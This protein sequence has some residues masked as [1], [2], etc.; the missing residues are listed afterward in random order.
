MTGGGAKTGP[1]V[2]GVG[3]T[4]PLRDNRPFRALWFA[5]SISFLGDSLGLVTLLLYVADTTGRALAVALL[6]LVGDFAPALLGPFTG[7]LSDRFDPKRVDGG[8]RPRAG[9]PGYSYRS[10][11]AFAAPAPPEGS[12]GGDPSDVSRGGGV[13]ARPPRTGG[14]NAR[15]VAHLDGYS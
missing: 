7:V 4:R 13:V 14:L 8:L 15:S 6:L 11:A 2:G 1:G 5:R 10:D 12:P 3:A 9:P